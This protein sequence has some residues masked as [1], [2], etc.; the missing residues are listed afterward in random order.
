MAT[1]EEIKQERIV[2]IQ[3]ICKSI[4]EK[5][6]KGEKVKLAKII[7]E[8]GMSRGFISVLKWNMIYVKNENGTVLFNRDK[9]VNRELAEYLENEFT[10]LGKWNNDKRY[11]E[12][13]MKSPEKYPIDFETTWV[14]FGFTRRDNAKRSLLRF[15][16]N[17]KDYYILTNEEINGKITEKRSDLEVIK[18]S[19]EGFVKWSACTQTPTA[20]NQY[21]R[22][23]LF[24][25]EVEKERKTLS[26]ERDELSELKLFHEHMVSRQK[27]YTRKNAELNCEINNKI[28]SG[29]PR[30]EVGKSLS[31]GTD[32]YYREYKDFLFNI[33]S[34]IDNKLFLLNTDKP[35]GQLSLFDHVTD[36]YSEE[37]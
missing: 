13:A 25:I 14:D 4:H 23:M 37:E 21:A 2:K 8:N 9:T 32:K 28:K 27:D 31:V 12:N 30:I 11:F 35:D 3:N 6:E 18:L 16:E 26:N 33:I 29:P 10:I 7:E 17:V 24:T 36:D 1:F 34:D 5:S 20:T 15:C 19:K 22:L